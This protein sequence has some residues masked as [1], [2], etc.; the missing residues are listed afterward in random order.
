[1][2]GNQCYAC[3]DTNCRLCNS[4]NNAQCMYCNRAYM[5]NT[6]NVC[7]SVAVTCAYNCIACVNSSNAYLCT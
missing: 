4:S 6:N 5:L 2:L 7:V 3:A 1:M